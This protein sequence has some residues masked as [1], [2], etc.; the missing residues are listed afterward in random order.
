M[1]SPW[2]GEFMGTFILILLGNGVCAN[3]LLKRSKAEGASRRSRTC[4]S[5]G[6]RRN[7]SSSA[8]ALSTLPL[9]P[10]H[11]RIEITVGRSTRALS[12][13]TISC[14]E[15][16]GGPLSSGSARP[17][18]ITAWSSTT[19]GARRS[20]LPAKTSASTEPL[21]SSII[22]AAHGLPSRLRLR[23]MPVSTPHSATSAPLLRPS[24]LPLSWV[25]NS[26]TLS[27]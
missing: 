8:C 16:L 20:K 13:A 3:V 7:N 10:S 21:R 17:R 15:I 6:L 5:P 19:S 4:V 12:R 1:A 2:F 23:V 27:A 9:R 18:T 11:T 25:A 14:T 26:A 22:I 24:R